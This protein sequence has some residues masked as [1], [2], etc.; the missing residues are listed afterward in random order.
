VQ[1]GVVI[2]GFGAAGATSEEDEEIAKAARGRC[3]DY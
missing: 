2:G 3:R 1:N